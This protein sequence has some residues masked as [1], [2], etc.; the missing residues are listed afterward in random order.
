VK[1]FRV[2]RII[3]KV[4]VFTHDI[5]FTAS[6]VTEPHHMLQVQEEGIEKYGLQVSQAK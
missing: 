4:L 2:W 5:V 1:E 3:L 6:V